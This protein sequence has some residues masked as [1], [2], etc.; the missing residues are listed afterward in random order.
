MR[1]AVI[2]DIHGLETWRNIADKVSDYDRIIFIGDY[3]D[4]YHAINQLQRQNLLDIIQ[5]RDENPD[6]VILLLGNHDMHYIIRGLECSGFS[7]NKYD[8][9]HRIYRDNLDKFK[10]IHREGYFIFS[11]AGLSSKYLK[12]YGHDSEDIDTAIDYVNS[13]LHINLYAFDFH[14]GDGSW[15]GNHPLQG[16]T[17]IRP[18]ALVEANEDSWLEDFVQVFGHT[19]SLDSE[20]FA[21]DN[22]WM[23]ICTDVLWD[24]KYVEIDGS[25]IKYSD[26]FSSKSNTSSI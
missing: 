13:R 19:K 10:M 12:Y 15:V 8:L 22:N 5:F 1:I 21:K 25:D 14:E 4:S 26:L 2:G 7:R 18:D 24:G 16:P 20:K 11:H 23:Y 6:K 17:W 9:F 3:V